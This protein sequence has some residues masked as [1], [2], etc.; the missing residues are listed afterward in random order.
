MF[1]FLLESAAR[2]LALAIVVWTGLSLFRIRSPRDQ[3]FAWA[4]VLLSAACMPLLIVAVQWLM[5]PPSLAWIPESSPSFFLRPLPAAISNTTASSMDFVGL[6]SVFYAVIVGVFLVRLASGLRR[7][8]RLVKKAIP[9]RQPWT[10]GRDV[11]V[12]RDLAIPATIGATILLPSDHSQWDDFTREAVLAH[13]SAHVRR[14]DFYTHLIAGFH[15][16]VF[17]FSPLAWWLRRRLLELAENASDDEAIVRVKDRT[18]Y[19]GLLVD[20]ASRAATT[21]F[22]GVEMARSGMVTVRVERMLGNIALPQRSS[23]LKCLLLVSVFIPILGFSAAAWSIHAAPKA[24]ASPLVVHVSTSQA[25]PVQ[26]TPVPVA[27]P[28]TPL[29]GWIDKEVPDIAAPE[30]RD[31]FLR[32]GSEEE[33]ALFIEQFWLRRD[34]TPS[35][36]EN[37]FR[38]EYYRRVAVANRRFG[39]GVAGWRTDRGRILIMRGEPDE[40]ETHAVGGTIQNPGGPPFE[41]W[42]YR[43]IEGVGANVIL[44][45]VDKAGDGNYRL[46]SPKELVSPALR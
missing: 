19:A 27:Q 42:L 10:Q 11:R 39:T 37:E 6:V 30:E 9:L 18:V 45:F 34:P 7:S 1:V 24:L 29:S 46:E 3:F 36:P 35:T 4:A 2:S 15:Q 28:Q 21:G 17:W 12:S 23:Q 41:R 25:A 26:A 33:R 22:V 5:A 32:L 20:F 38:T 13:E 16:A 44:E 14:R 31:A 40:V 43:R 8:R